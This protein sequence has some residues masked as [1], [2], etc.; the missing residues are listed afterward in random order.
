MLTAS[1][2]FKVKV[3]DVELVEEAPLLIEMLEDVGAEW[4]SKICPIGLQLANDRDTIMTATNFVYL[5]CF[6]SIIS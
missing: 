1:T 6:I 5:K 2:E 4:S 3:T